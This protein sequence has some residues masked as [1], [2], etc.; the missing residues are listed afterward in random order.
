MRRLLLTAILAVLATTPASPA[1]KDYNGRW[2][3]FGTTE[4]GQCVPGFRIKVRVFRGKAYIIGYSLNGTKTAISSRGQ[5]NI[6]Y[7]NGV[8]VIMASGTL[9]KRTG[10]GRWH[11]PT[12]RCSGRWRAEKL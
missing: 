12:Y 2:T 4:K 10:D 9:K 7:V 3:I 6:K 1:Q 11:Y 5:V 8:D